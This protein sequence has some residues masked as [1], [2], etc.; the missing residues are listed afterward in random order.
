M[1]HLQGNLQNV[2]DALYELGVIEPVLKMDWKPSLEEMDQGS[3]DLNNAIRI[4]NTCANDRTRLMTELVKLD[5][6]ALE[7]LAME[8]AREYAGF[9]TREELH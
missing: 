7:I 6:H 5:R 9:H 2:F 8:V 1:L 3:E 4:A